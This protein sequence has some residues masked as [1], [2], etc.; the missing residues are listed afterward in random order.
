MSSSLT[1][2]ATSADQVVTNDLR[3]RVIRLIYS[4]N[5]Q[6]LL[7]LHRLPREKQ[8]I[9]ANRPLF[10]VNLDSPCGLGATMSWLTGVLAYSRVQRMIPRVIVTNQNYAVSPG[11]D[12]LGEYF[13]RKGA[14]REDAMAPAL[15]KEQYVRTSVHLLA[16]MRNSYK[17]LTLQQ[18]H[19]LFFGSIDFSEEL[20][21][22]AD[23]FCETQ[24]IGS[25][26][27]GVHYR[28]TDKVS[29]ATQ[30]AWKAMVKTI[31]GALNSHTRNIFVASDEIEFVTFIRKAFDS[32]EVIDLNCDE[33]H[34]G[35]PAHLTPG[36]PKT[37][38]SEAIRTMIVLSRC[39]LLI[40]NRSQLSAWAKIYNPKLPTIALGELL[41]GD[42]FAFPENLVRTDVDI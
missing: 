18:V 29:E 4:E 21:A 42:L 31:S 37:K 30:V 19:D 23:S 39:G 6:R 26:T 16:R 14:L 7:T 22:E 11:E 12:W 1:T 38:A 25:Q 34:A 17:D 2:D 5:G 20:L 35:Q 27:I 32:L 41:V 40:K 15:P 28:G 36:N 10:A 3:T 24:H 13:I 8:L 9:A 33:L